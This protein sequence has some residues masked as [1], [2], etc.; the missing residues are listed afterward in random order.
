MVHNGCL[1]QTGPR[2]ILPNTSPILPF[3]HSHRLPPVLSGEGPWSCPLALRSVGPGA[4]ADR[5][6]LGHQPSLGL[7]PLLCV[8]WGTQKASPAQASPSPGPCVQLTDPS[9]HSCH[10]N[11]SLFKNTFC[12]MTSGNT[13]AQFKPCPFTGWQAGPGV[14]LPI[15][16]TARLTLHSPFP[17]SQ[18]PGDCIRFRERFMSLHFSKI[19]ILSKLFEA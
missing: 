6:F 1:F 3:P 7:S 19:Q 17:P 5:G 10:D 11:H 18:D 4:A 9:S 8:P 13:G 16:L 14:S 12:G 15:E 2:S